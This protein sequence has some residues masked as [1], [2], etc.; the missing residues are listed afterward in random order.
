MNTCLQRPLS[1][2]VEEVHLTHPAGFTNLGMSTG[3]SPSEKSVA[4]DE[5]SPV[6]RGLFFLALSP[7]S[8][9]L[10]RLLFHGYSQCF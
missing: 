5:H 2:P 10:F 1:N 3:M 6:I 9:L 7:L 8:M 4:E